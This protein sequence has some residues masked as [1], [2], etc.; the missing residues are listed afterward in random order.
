MSRPLRFTML[1]PRWFSTQP[2]PA[3]IAIAMPAMTAKAANR[4]PLTPHFGKPKPLSL[5]LPMPNRNAIACPNP[6]MKVRR[7][8]RDT[9]L[10]S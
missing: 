10:T 1:P 2:A 3:L 4:L 6:K 9:R 8:Y 7:Q 5:N